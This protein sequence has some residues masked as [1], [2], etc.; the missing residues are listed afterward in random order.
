MSTT[1][2]IVLVLLVLFLIDLYAWRGI[3]TAI[4]LRSAALQRMVRIPYW[5]VS[6]GMLIIIGFAAVRIEELRSSHNNAFMYTAI[7]IFVLL[8]LPKLVIIVFHGLED[9]WEFFR[10]AWCKLALGAGSSEVDPGRMRFL[11][12]PKLFLA[13]HSNSL[14]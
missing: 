6:I 12:E 4:A 1:L 8:L 11:S 3:Q 10:W 2:R 13:I 7:G 9:L 14:L 5:A